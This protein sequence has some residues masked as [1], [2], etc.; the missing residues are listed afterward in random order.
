MGSARSPE[1]VLSM[2]VEELW[3]PILTDC[4]RFV[5]KS[6]IQ[7]QVAGGK[8]RAASLLTRMLGMMV[9]KAE[10]KSGTHIHAHTHAHPYTH[11]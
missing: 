5:R 11:L 8:S 1:P 10:Q 9:L 4:G 7:A 2:R 3:V 6:F